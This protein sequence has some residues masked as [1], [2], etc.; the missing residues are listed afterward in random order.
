MQV[1]RNTSLK[2]TELFHGQLSSY[3][4][5]NDW[6]ENWI[7]E[8]NHDMQNKSSLSPREL[9]KILLCHTEYNH[10]RFE[11][12][13]YKKKKKKL[14]MFPPHLQLLFT[15]NPIQS[16][17]GWSSLSLS[18]FLEAFLEEQL[19]YQD[20]KYPREVSDL[21][22]W[23]PDETQV[24]LWSY[25]CTPH[26]CEPAERPPPTTESEVR[27]SRALTSAGLYEVKGDFAILI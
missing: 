12:W 15:V 2:A 4:T 6:S 8:R 27:Y 14:L 20:A 19:A 7:F 1:R 9:K 10:R 17:C 18:L 22:G 3:C 25:C 21:S 23:Q 26:C 5:F 16:E 24:P 13:L 11:M